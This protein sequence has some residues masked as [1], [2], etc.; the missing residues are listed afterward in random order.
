MSYRMC[1]ARR[2]NL[3]RLHW[4]NETQDIVDPDNPWI[5]HW[6]PIER[7]S[8][9]IQLIIIQRRQVFEELLR[10][11]AWRLKLSNEHHHLQDLFQMLHEIWAWPNI[12]N[13]AKLWFTIK[14]F[15]SFTENLRGGAMFLNLRGT[16]N[17]CL[18][19]NGQNSHY[20]CAQQLRKTISVVE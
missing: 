18:T 1:K 4:S 9:Q 17:I 12:V 11:T 20:Y 8:W 10:V 6:N 13:P 16:I 7:Y 15:K 19:S 3:D 14:I 2:K 5:A